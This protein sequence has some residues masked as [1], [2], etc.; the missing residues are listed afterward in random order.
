MIK[1]AIKKGDIIKVQYTG[2][3][4]D[5]TVFDSSETH[6][7]PLKFEVGAA[8]LIKGFNSSVVGKDVGDEYTVKIQPEEAYGAYNEN[9]SQEVPKAEFPNDPKPEA[10]MMLQLGGPDGQVA[11]ATIK[12]VTDDNVIIDLNHP[13][14]GKVLNFNIKI[15][16]TGC[17]PDPPSACGCGCG[18]DH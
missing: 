1:L 8:Q 2:T 4:D 15:V 7:Q 12:E 5:G 14:A 17:E 11:I 3:F 18:H 9:M 13:M 16:E 10:G 6:G